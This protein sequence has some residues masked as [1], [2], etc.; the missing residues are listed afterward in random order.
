[1]SRICYSKVN[2]QNHHMKSKKNNHKVSI[3]MGSQSDYP[4]MKLSQK[5]LKLLNILE[6]KKTRGENYYI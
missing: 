6:I 4:T 1:M 5:V 3:I 2:I